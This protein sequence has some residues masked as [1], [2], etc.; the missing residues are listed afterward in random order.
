MDMLLGGMGWLLALA[1]GAA[2]GAALVN[3]KMSAAQRAMAEELAATKARMQ[4]RESA[5]TEVEMRA[6]LFAQELLKDQAQQLAQTNQT[7]L[8]SLLT[9]LKVQF[10]QFTKEVSGLKETSQKDSSALG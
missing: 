9:P 4:E 8:S 5:N 1:V 10:E 6:K 3:W 2:L 7:N